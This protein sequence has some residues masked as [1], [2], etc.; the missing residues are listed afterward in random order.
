MEST[1]G[2]GTGPGSS[3]KGSTPSEG[4]E[5]GLEGKNTDSNTRK[6]RKIHAAPER[7]DGRNTPAPEHGKDTIPHYVDIVML[8]G[9]EKG[10]EQPGYTHQKAMTEAGHIHLIEVTY[11]DEMSWE[12]ALK[13]K[14]TKYT[15]L[16]KLLELYGYKE[17]FHILEPD[18]E[19]EEAENENSSEAVEQ[20]TAEE[21][22]AWEVG[23]HDSSETGGADF[24]DEAEYF[25]GG[26][27]YSSDGGYEY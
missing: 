19:A 2:N 18:P 9:T 14:Y 5:K 6:A 15:P 25:E 4:M 22:A 8:E 17:E 10:N 23:A 11:T 1:P 7:L 27:C 3:A 26:G 21:W 16:V 12:E 20:C 13:T 24:Y